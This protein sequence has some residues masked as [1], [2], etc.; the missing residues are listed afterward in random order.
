MSCNRSTTPARTFA[1]IGRAVFIELLRRKDVYV[2]LALMA[3]YAIGVVS[4][5]LV[6]IDNASTGTFLL[7]LGMTLSYYAAH[8]LTLVLTARQIPDELENRTIYPLLAKPV[9]RGAFLFSK[10]GA[11]VLCGIAALTGLW[12]L[13]VLPVPRMES[14]Q[15]ATLIQAILLFPVSLA[16]LAALALLISLVAPKGVVLVVA[17]SIF[18]FGDKIGGL[19]AR[20]AESNVWLTPVAWLTAYLPDFSKLNL[21]TRYTDG[22]GPVPGFEY[23]GLICYG[24]IVTAFGLSLSNIIFQRRAL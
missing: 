10:W 8:V 4:F 18:F 17:G 11:C 20:G 14:Y 2:L 9:G 1:L 13:G 6:G 21:I 5:T 19:L 22:I 15:A 24:V 23:A 12:T 3:V 16:L 7:N